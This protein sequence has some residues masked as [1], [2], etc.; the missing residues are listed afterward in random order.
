MLYNFYTFHYKFI[1]FFK[2]KNIKNYLQITVHHLVFC[3]KDEVLV[4]LKLSYNSI[5][6]PSHHYTKQNALFMLYLCS[7][8]NQWRMVPPDTWSGVQVTGV[9]TSLSFMEDLHCRVW[10]LYIFFF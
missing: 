3:P 7:I 1:T 5:L 4:S 10:E 9:H 2:R 8:Y 6:P